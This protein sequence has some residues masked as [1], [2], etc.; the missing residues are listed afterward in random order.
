VADEGTAVLGVAT[1][2]SR[3]VLVVRR[4]VV[5][6]RDKGVEVEPLQTWRG[7]ANDEFRSIADL[8]DTLANVLDPKREGAPLAIAVK[9]TES[10]RGRPTNQYDQKTRAEGA[11]M[12]AAASQGRRY[13][14]YRS[15]QLGRGTRLSELASVSGDYPADSEGTDAVAA[16]C[17]A[18]A[19]L[20]CEA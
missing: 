16:A 9:R 3:G 15:N 2:S 17:A 1:S 4:V 11:A 8:V 7:T 12:T 20:G 10:T 14:Q 18:L 19:E 6:F 5:R 13:F